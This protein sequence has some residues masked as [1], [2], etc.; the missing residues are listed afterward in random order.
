MAK[1][2]VKR[3]YLWR[4]VRVLKHETAGQCDFA[5]RV[6]MAQEIEELAYMNTREQSFD[7]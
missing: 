4:R 3:R 7:S 5:T 1:E 6:L 2:N